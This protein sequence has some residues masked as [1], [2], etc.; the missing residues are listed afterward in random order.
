MNDFE[1]GLVDTGADVTIISPKSWNAKWSVQ[2]VHTQFVGIDK[3]SQIK[4]S[5]QR[6][7]CV[8]SE[9]QKGS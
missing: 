7:K 2:K 5:V 4:Q 6:I 1:I 8:E 3:F 9:E